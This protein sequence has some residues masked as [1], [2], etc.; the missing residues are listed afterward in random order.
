M[1]LR[2]NGHQ[3][4][5][6]TE[7]MAMVTGCLLLMGANYSGSVPPRDILARL[8]AAKGTNLALHATRY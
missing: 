7:I 1:L 5:N 6:P 8:V 2:K 3:N 4:A